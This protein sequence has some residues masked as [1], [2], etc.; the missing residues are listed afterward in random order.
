[1]CLFSLARVEPA[2]LAAGSALAT[3]LLKGA[4]LVER[5]GLCPRIPPRD[6]WPTLEVAIASAIPDAL[7]RA[8]AAHDRRAAA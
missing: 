7:T 2:P 8:F 1:M 5:G 4:P 3:A 6:D